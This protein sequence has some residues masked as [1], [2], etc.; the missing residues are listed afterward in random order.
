M[1]IK[2]A[3]GVIIALII[4]TL[5]Y[6]KLT[7]DYSRTIANFKAELEQKDTL[8]V[9]S[10]RVFSNTIAELKYSNDSIT[11]VLLAT[12]GSL[13]VKPKRITQIQYLEAKVSKT[14]TIVLKD[15]IFKEDTRLDTTLLDNWYS[16]NLK[17]VYPDTIVTTPSFKSE[18]HVII[19]KVKETI[20]PPK[21]FF[22]LRWFQKK[23]TVLKVEVV[24]KNPYI[25]NTENKF[26][27]VI[28]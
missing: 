3:V 12:A 11:K 2:I 20:N 5:G 22:L 17:L 16:I 28:K 19:H 9:N 4:V 1:K 6:F 25:T 23:H 14:D 26:I 27:E 24:E 7:N 18:K 13:K 21:K 10:R 8:L 15:T